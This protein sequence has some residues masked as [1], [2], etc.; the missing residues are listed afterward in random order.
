MTAAVLQILTADHPKEERLYL[1]ELFKLLTH[2]PLKMIHLFR[3]NHNPPMDRQPSNR[4]ALP[5]HQVQGRI[6]LLKPY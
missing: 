2:Q 3:I 1:L 4:L 5:A 6:E